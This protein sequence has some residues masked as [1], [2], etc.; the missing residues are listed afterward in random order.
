MSIKAVLFDLDGT[1]LPMDQDLFIKIYF[2]EITSYLVKNGGYDSDKFIKTMWQGIEAM[3]KN[4]GKETNEKVFWDA[5]SNEYG[6]EKVEKDYH[7]FESFYK[8]RF[9]ETKGAC[10]STENTKKIIEYLKKQGVKI[11]LATNPLFPLVA[12]KMRIG[13]AGLEP[14]DFELVTTYENIG[15]SK[16]N[17]NYYVE[18][19]KRI[20][21][22]PSECLMVGNDTSDDMVAKSIG[23]DVFLLTDCLINTKNEDISCYPNG[24]FEDLIEYIN[25]K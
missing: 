7:I 6:K 18:I 14:S 19:S 21:V 3:M 9:K 22:L 25:N 5:F 13:W 24:S 16:P 12:T 20:N 23:M 4:D 11:V 10:K 17:P 8:E 2:G 15:Y 1:L